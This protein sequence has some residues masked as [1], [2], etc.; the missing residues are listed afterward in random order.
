MA[1]IIFWHRMT[2]PTEICAPAS[3]VKTMVAH[4]T[5]CNIHVGT[6]PHQ[7]R[8][9]AFD[10]GIRVGDKLLTIDNKEITSNTSVEQVR[11]LLRGDPG[12]DVMIQFQRE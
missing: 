5:H 11:N 7:S 3:S 12:T 8:R 1:V 2:T 6:T 10:F 9:Y 4:A